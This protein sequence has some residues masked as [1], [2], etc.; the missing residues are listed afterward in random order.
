MVD[1]GLVVVACITS[2]LMVIVFSLLLYVE[3][4]WCNVFFANNTVSLQKYSN[5]QYSVVQHL[6]WVPITNV[7]T[8]LAPAE[9]NWD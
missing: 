5:Y 3:Y 2:S 9:S 1:S 6:P 7:Y 4:E 8:L